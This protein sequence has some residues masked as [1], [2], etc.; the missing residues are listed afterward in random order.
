MSRYGNNIR[1]IA[2]TDELLEKIRQAQQQLTIF[3]KAAIPGA[4]A[5]AYPNGGVQSGSPGQTNPDKNGSPDK[6][7]PRRKDRADDGRKNGTG[8]D[9]GDIVNGDLNLT[10][11]DDPG[12]IK[13]KDCETGEP[14]DLILNA[15]AN[16]GEAKFQHPEG[17]SPDG[18]SE[19]QQGYENW[20]LGY[21]WRGSSAYFGPSSTAGG[22]PYDAPTPDVGSKG[23]VGF[24]S[25]SPAYTVT[26][27]RLVGVTYTTPTTAQVNVEYYLE[28]DTGPNTGWVLNQQVWNRFSCNDEIG[29]SRCI[30]AIPAAY[31]KW[32]EQDPNYRHQL[33][34]SAQD[35]GFVSSSHDDGLP[36]KFRNDVG[37]G[38]GLNNM[39]LCTED[40]TEVTMSALTDGS[41]AF[42][43]EDGFGMPDE[44]AKIFH[45]DKDGKY[46]DLL[47][48]DQ[49][50]Y[51]RS[52]SNPAA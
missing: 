5:I 2:Q 19:N 51:M 50:N 27:S 4:R 46:K 16:E 30:A 32:Q 25:E 48:K 31:T 29:T 23:G 33:A 14:I 7:D 35:G 15:G 49:Y 24:R 47:Q 39:R 12:K 21:Y 17:W 28:W 6:L 41:F 20:E 40:G 26:D 11:G 52:T 38:R 8:T 42:F 10:P 22:N 9:G 18:T 13:L 43:K 1:R 3:E 34:F 37:S 36:S 44:D 45:F